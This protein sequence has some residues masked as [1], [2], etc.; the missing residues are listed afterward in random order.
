MILYSFIFFFYIHLFVEGVEGRADQQIL[1]SIGKYSIKYIACYKCIIC[2]TT[3]T[4]E[5]YS[6]MLRLGV[7]KSGHSMNCS[8]CEY[9]EEYVYY[10]YG[11][12]IYKKI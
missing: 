5:P 7:S 1:L 10:N 8:Q 9:Y 4:L 2:R 12:Y 11:Y 3:I 6:I